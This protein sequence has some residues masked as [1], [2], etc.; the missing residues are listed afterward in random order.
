MNAVK[1]I[2]SGIKNFM[3]VFSF[4]VNLVLVVIVVGLLLFIFDI[5]NNVVTPLVAGLHSS[6]V[7]L[8]EATIDWTIPVRDNIPVVL[9]VPLETNTV[10]T[11]T[12]NVPLSVA[13]T[14]NLPGVGTLNNAQVFLQ[15]P[16]GLELPVALDLDVP[17]NQTLPIS[18]DVRAVIPLEMTQLDD[19]IQNLR[20]LFD[21]LT[22]ALYN[23]PGNF[24]EAGQL[25]GNVLAGQPVNLL[26]DNAYTADPWAGFSRT[27]GLGYDLSFEQVPARNRPVETGIVPEGGIPGL[28]SQVRP[29]VWNAGG[30]ESVNAQAAATMSGMGIDPYY[31]NGGYATALQAQA[32]AAQATEGETGGGSP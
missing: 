19:P 12:D 1:T 8:N 15:L 5:K 4:I 23:L 16:R 24:G 29:E 22:R 27:A 18:L 13:A 3:I 31:Y 32:A 28:D 6:F 20:L 11:L 9:T 17:I 14:I 30:P 25:I 2:G 10:V 7:G 26:A 21:P